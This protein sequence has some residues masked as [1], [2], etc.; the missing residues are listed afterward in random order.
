M[1]HYAKYTLMKFIDPTE[2]EIW[3]RSG[4]KLLEVHNSSKLDVFTGR[5]EEIVPSAHEGYAST[6]ERLS[7]DVPFV[8][9]ELK[10]IIGLDNETS[11]S[12]LDKELKSQ[13]SRIASGLE[14]IKNKTDE[15]ETLKKTLI[16][17]SGQIERTNTYVDNVK[18]YSD[19]LKAMTEKMER[20]L[21][22]IRQAIG[23]VEFDRI[24][25][26]PT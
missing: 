16:D 12:E 17:Q 26:E 23:S 2:L 6:K 4:W 14:M 13:Q 3:T 20:D 21:A 19:R 8:M 24:T 9:N 1:D 10:C 5:R 22:R 25:K 15:V 7:F 18:N 11:L